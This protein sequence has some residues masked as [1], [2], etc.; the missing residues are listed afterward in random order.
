VLELVDSLFDGY[1]G[2]D[3]E[4]T[5]R[6]MSQAHSFFIPHLD[7]VADLP[8]LMR[9]LQ[10]KVGNYFTCITCNRPY[11][12]LEGIR[13]HMEDK[14]H[15]AIDY[16]EAGQ[17]EL[18]PFYDFSATYPD[19]DQI[20]DSVRDM[21]LAGDNGPQAIRVQD[22]ELV[23]PSGRTLGHRELRRYY[24]Q[25]F[26]PVDTRESIAVARVMAQ[27]VVANAVPFLVYALG[28]GP[29][30]LLFSFSPY[31]V[32][33]PPPHSSPLHRYKAL[34]HK[35]FTMP[36]ETI[37]RDQAFVARR[38]KY[39]V[40]ALCR[41]SPRSWSFHQQIT[42]MTTDALSPVYASVAIV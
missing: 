34:G 40:E 25:Q 36:S 29:F 35:G 41:P 23:L 7:Y 15:K 30:F 31:F 8:G 33:S 18:G 24:K 3:L 21:V 39:A 4:D 12:S 22:M 26:K 19:D 6:H 9:Y 11:N 17:D 37:R 1:R 14:G 38:T 16:D 42:H 28:G 10:V 5:L 32:G 13:A 27:C 20:D 2:T